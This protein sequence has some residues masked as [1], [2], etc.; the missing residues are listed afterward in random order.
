MTQLLEQAIAAVHKLSPDQQD[1]I[2]QIILHELADEHRRD[3]AFA[4]S[5]ST[6]ARLAAKARAAVQAGKIMLPD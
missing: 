5:Q 2:A 6:L 4:N 3:A 1:H